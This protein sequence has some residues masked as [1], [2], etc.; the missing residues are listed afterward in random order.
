[1][2]VL[3]EKMNPSQSVDGSTPKLADLYRFLGCRIHAVVEESGPNFIYLPVTPEV[4][5]KFM[6]DPSMANRYLEKVQE[7]EQHA[8]SKIVP[9]IADDS[10]VVPLEVSTPEFAPV[11]MLDPVEPK[12]PMRPF[13]LQALPTA[14]CTVRVL[15]GALI[16]EDGDPNKVAPAFSVFGLSKTGLDILFEAQLSAN[17]PTVALRKPMLKQHANLWIRNPQPEFTYAIKRES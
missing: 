2:F 14:D 8:D 13:E 6:M 4:Y 9:L 7:F 5:G 17:S 3:F 16:R 11:D 15:P 10:K 12:L 1:M